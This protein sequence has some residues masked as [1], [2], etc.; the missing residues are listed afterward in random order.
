M[1]NSKKAYRKTEKSKQRKTKDVRY[2]LKYIDKQIK[3]A[4][5]QGKFYIILNNKVI[6]ERFF[7]E[8][9][10]YYIYELPKVT[11]TLYIKG[12]NVDRFQDKMKISWEN[13]K[14]GI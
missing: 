14:K 8:P 2:V 10:Y 4:C 5:N 7:D 9:K 13:Q 6:R 3:D 11:D 12:Y 1:L